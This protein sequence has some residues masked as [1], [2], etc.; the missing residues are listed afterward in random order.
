M[1]PASLFDRIYPP[2][3]AARVA[4]VYEQREITYEELRAATVRAAEALHALGISE[5]DRVAILLNDSPEFIASFV[6]AI[7]I[8]AIAVP[9]NMALRKDDQL[10]ILKDCGARAAIME[11][12]A[13]ET[14]FQPAEDGQAAESLRD[15]QQLLVV[16]RGEE[17]ARSSYA[18][19]SAQAFENAPRKT[20]GE[21]FPLR[22][23]ESVP[24]FILYTSG[25]TGEPKGAVHR[26]TD[27]FYTNETFCR[28][29]LRLREGDRIFSSSRLPFAYGLGNSFTFPLLNGQTTILCREKPAPEVIARVFQ[30]YRPTIFFGVP[31]VYRMLLEYHR[32]ALRVPT[33]VGSLLSEKSPTEVGTLNTASLRLSISAGEALPAQMG[34][35]WQRIF[36]VAVLDG[37]GS[38]EMLHM[39]M[40]NHEGDLR[41]GSS[42]KLLRGYEARLI[43]HDGSATQAGEVGNLWIRGGSAAVGYWQRPETTAETF[44]DGWLRT[45]DL[46]RCDRDEF[47]W[48]MGRSDDCFKPTGQWVSPVE[49]EGVLLRSEHARAAAVVEGFDRDGLSCVCAFVVLSHDGGD[50]TTAEDELRAFCEAALPRFKQP[51]RY[52]FVADLPYTA[53]GKVQRFKLREQLRQPAGRATY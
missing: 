27:I 43:D 39:F 37:I 47:W 46:Y 19:V 20:L 53:T 41:Y 50:A 10:F 32:Q 13:A 51:R 25:S 45:G 33:S 30:D 2:K 26:Q 3:R 12:A 24:A 34:E 1:K 22:G 6:G 15:L 14:I 52:L 16:S 4:V 49:V 11:T 23:N 31:V 38:T 40:S 36:G 18:G 7:S 21:E 8:G 44:V 35:D 9:I 28:E 29:V 42:G 48:H 17:S 5:G